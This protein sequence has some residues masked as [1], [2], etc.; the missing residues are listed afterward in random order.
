MKKKGVCANI[1]GCA[2]DIEVKERWER[3][4]HNSAIPLLRIY[5]GEMKRCPRGDWLVNVHSSTI[6]NGQ[7]L[8]WAK[9][10]STGDG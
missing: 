2:E 8:D 7:K 1:E 10:P 9:Y 5:P 3:I 4:T 6:D